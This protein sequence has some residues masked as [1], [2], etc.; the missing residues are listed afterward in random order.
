[1]QTSFMLEAECIIKMAEIRQPIT[2]TQG[3]QLVKS[4]INRT[5][6]KNAMP[7]N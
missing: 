4:L 1:V 6:M 3:L 2:T 7:G 5:S